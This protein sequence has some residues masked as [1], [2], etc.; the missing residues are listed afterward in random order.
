MKRATIVL[1]VL[2]ALGVLLTACAPATE[3][4][5]TVE[6][7]GPAGE[8]IVVTTTPSPVEAAPAPAVEFARNETLYTSGKQ[9]GPPTNWN[10]IMTWA[11]AMGTI[12]L[13]Y[14]TL[15]LYDP[16]TNEYIPW[17]AESGQWT[18]DTVYEVTL[19]QGINWTDGEP[20]TAEDVV[21]TFELGK[22]P[23]VPYNT[24]W[25]WLESAEAVDDYTVRFTFSQANYQEWANYLY[26]I[27]I[28]P[29]HLWEGRS[30]EE[31]ATGA[32]ENPIG[33]GPYLYESHSE[34]RMVWV[35]NDDWWAIDM[36]GLSVAPK[37]IVDIVNSSN[38][39]S[40]G[41][42][43]QGQLDLSNNFL[44]GIASLR[45]PGRGYG[46][47]TYFSGPPYMLSANTAWLVMNTTKPPMDDPA[48]RRAMAFAIDVD[49]IVNVVYGNI[50]QKANPTG[51]LP[52][53]EQYIDQAV[54]DELGFTYDP[55][56]AN[57]I[58]DEA[59]YLDVNGDGF[60]E[61]PDGSPIELTII[62]PNGWT[63]WMESI[64]VI[65]E[66]AQAVGINLT[67]D[68]PDYSALVD[69]RN[70][71]N[72]DMVINNDRQVSN[73]PWTYYDYIFRLPIQEA[74]TTTNFGRYENEEAW[75]LVQQLDQTPV[76]DLEGMRSIMSQL[77]RIH[78]TDLPIIPL[79]YNGMWSQYSNA[80]WTN[81]PS[82]EEGANHY[83]PATWNGY[84]NMTA[85]LMLTELEPAGE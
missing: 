10:P 54:V 74:Q 68:F 46:I 80:V 41:M 79:W 81:W 38:N 52:I 42:L 72:F 27:A 58:L 37:R 55:A 53:W 62:V 5:V 15:F 8:T 9:W 32:N 69:A 18:S 47:E 84:W 65:A 85:I 35:R 59:G 29:K 17:L 2:A 77:Q 24:L 51:L 25:N 4:V 71:G 36:L 63:D 14:E 66:S 50:V 34:D 13:C 73:T 61:M 57:A 22:I 1:C 40:L 11:Y 39:V 19:R 56:Q 48:F 76:D 75:A 31:I 20:L 60:R 30:D 16:L 23:A 70:S 12:G 26:N 6:V 82:A 3:T 67:P 83:L 7:P 44:P 21:F 64:R 78:L 33:T 45:D 43:L 49:K 28:V